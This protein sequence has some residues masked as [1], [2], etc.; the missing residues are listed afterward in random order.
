[1]LQELLDKYSNAPKQGGA[2]WKESRRN[3]VGG[4]EAQH[5]YSEDRSRI[6]LAKTKLGI[7]VFNG[8]EHT[9]WGNVMEMAGKN[10]TEFLFGTTVY[11]D[12]RVLIKYSPDGLLVLPDIDLEY[13]NRFT[14]HLRMP[15]I[16][17]KPG[18]IILMEYKSPTR[19]LPNLS[20]PQSYVPQLLAGLN[21]V[22]ISRYAL[23]DDTRYRVISIKDFKKSTNILTWFAVYSDTPHRISREKKIGGKR[24]CYD[25]LYISPQILADRIEFYIRTIMTTG[26]FKAHFTKRFYNTEA[27]KE[28]SKKEDIYDHLAEA[29][30]E[31]GEQAYV[32]GFVLLEV[33]KKSFLQFFKNEDFP[34]RAA[35]SIRKFLDALQVVRDSE[36]P[37]LFEFSDSDF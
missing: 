10:F 5:F 9:M 23:F 4:S 11:E 14:D 29:K 17:V 36:C 34:E 26:K 2:E 27:F 28:G 25:M 22:P 21:A 12:G 31:L 18:D 20:V 35:K 30:Q 16:D 8:N 6:Q 13:I 1:M 32:I 24:I 19:R 3:T 7:S 37:D 15:R 33:E